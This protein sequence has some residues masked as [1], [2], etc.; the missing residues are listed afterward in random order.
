MSDAASEPR[1]PPAPSPTTS[2]RLAALEAERRGI[3]S[4]FEWQI[5]GLKPGDLPERAR[6]LMRLIHRTADQ[7]LQ[8]RK[9]L[10]RAGYKCEG[11]WPDGAE[12]AQT[13]PGADFAPWQEAAGVDKLVDKIT[14]LEGAAATSDQRATEQ[15][16]RAAAACERANA[17]EARATEA[18]AS[19]QAASM[20][21]AA[22]EQ[23][24]RALADQLQAAQVAQGIA[25]R[26]YDALQRSREASRVAAAEALEHLQAVRQELDD[27]GVLPQEDDQSKRVAALLEAGKTHEKVHEELRAEADGRTDVANKEIERANRLAER[28]QAAEQALQVA[29]RDAGAERR[30]AALLEEAVREKDL[31]C[32]QLSA[33][34]AA[35]AAESVDDTLESRVAALEQ[36]IVRLV[37]RG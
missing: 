17:A 31:A 16:E 26:S 13:K 34:I 32:E 29:Q 28:C 10:E 20:A 33:T 27:A 8:I 23:R 22:S 7:Q 35:Q 6:S 4:A 36:A 19:G 18:A 21:A 2:E 30:R 15:Q 5:E 9:A 25:E 14:L 11:S 12:V 24:A 3:C 1:D 37:G